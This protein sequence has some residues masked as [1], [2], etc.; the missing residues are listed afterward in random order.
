MVIISNSWLEIFTAIKKLDKFPF[1]IVIK[2][3]LINK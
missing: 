2:L 3:S 1:I